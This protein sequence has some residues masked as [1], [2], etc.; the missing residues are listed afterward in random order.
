MGIPEQ[1]TQE[2]SGPDAA[3]YS[4]SDLSNEIHQRLAALGRIAVQGEVSELKRA[5][6]GHLYFKLKDLDAVLSCAIWRSRVASA[7]RFDLKEGDR[8]VAHGRPGRLPPAR[9][10]QSDCRSPGSARRG[11]LDG[12]L[13]EGQAPVARARLVRSRASAADLAARRRLGHQSRWCRAAG[14][15]A[16]AQPA[17][18]ALS[19]AFG[20]LP[21]AGTG[22]LPGDRRGRAAPRRQRGRCDRV[23]ARRGLTRRP[24][25]LQ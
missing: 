22:S 11:R 17:L 18:A 20:A 4:V 14:F 9:N 25:G 3:V 2:Q 13:R 5:G 21:G 1:G 19:G 7:L 16:H 12:A 6:S 24:V 15:L 23:G 8:V 10:L